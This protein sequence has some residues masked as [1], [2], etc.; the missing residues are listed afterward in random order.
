MFWFIFDLLECVLDVVSFDGF[1]EFNNLIIMSKFF[2]NDVD[3]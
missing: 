3:E 1:F 2:I